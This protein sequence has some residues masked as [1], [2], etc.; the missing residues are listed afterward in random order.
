M[1]SN[2]DKQN[3]IIVIPINQQQPQNNAQNYNSRQQS[4]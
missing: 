2:N 4:H 1:N 3:Q